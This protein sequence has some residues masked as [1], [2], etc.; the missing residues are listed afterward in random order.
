MGKLKTTYFLE[1]DNAILYKVKGQKKLMS[2]S[3][4]INGK[5]SIFLV[6]DD[7]RRWGGRHYHRRLGDFHK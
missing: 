1:E 2:K 6:N 4:I 3:L 7:Y 5:L